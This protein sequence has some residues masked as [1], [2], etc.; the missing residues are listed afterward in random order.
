MPVGSRILRPTLRC[1]SCSSACASASDPDRNFQQN[2]E[3]SGAPLFLCSN[4]SQSAIRDPCME[5]VLR[6][7]F[8][9]LA[10]LLASSNLA[11]PQPPS[12][13][14]PSHPIDAPKPA[15]SN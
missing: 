15:A 8:L 14:H 7:S 2:G 9:L 1:A 12:P 13:H 3:P 5:R 4:H 6:S 10:S 11:R